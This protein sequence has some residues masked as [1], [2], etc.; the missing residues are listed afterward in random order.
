MRSPGSKGTRAPNEPA[1]PHQTTSRP[2][3]PRH[4]Y[5]V[6]IHIASGLGVWGSLSCFCHVRSGWQDQ[7]PTLRLTSDVQSDIDKC[8]SCNHGGFV[9]EEVPV[10]VPQMKR[11][12]GI[13]PAHRIGWPVGVL[14]ADEL[15]PVIVLV[16]SLQFSGASSSDSLAEAMRAKYAV[17]S[18]L[19]SDPPRVTG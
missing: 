17:G 1:H 6:N 13:C 18:G 10:R 14:N 8:N 4:T 16:P 7:A 12:V 11:A 3:A 9:A 15:Q 5:R 2:S 19:A